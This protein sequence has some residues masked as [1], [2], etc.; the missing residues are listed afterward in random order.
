M[1]DIGGLGVPFRT[2]EEYKAM[3]E[4]AQNANRAKSAFLAHMS[5]EMRTPMNSIIG[6]SELALDA[7]IPQKTREYLNLI[8]D[9]SKWLLQLINDILDISKIESGNMKLEH[10]PFDLHEIFIACRT[11][12]APKAA[13]KNIDLFFYAEP[14]VG[15]MLIGDPMRLRQVLI[16]LLSN[17]VKF[18][19]AGI[20]K[21]AAVIVNNYNPQNEYCTLRFEIKDTGI[22]MNSEQIEQIFKPFTQADVGTTRKYGGTGLGL[23]IT[24]NII[25]LM[26]G[27]LNIESKPGA[28]TKISYEITFS[29]T[30]LEDETLKIE[31]IVNT[32]EKPLFEGDI[33]V[34]EDNNM[35][36]RVIV[37][38]LKRVGFNVELAENGREGIEI[39]RRRTEKGGSPFDLIF[40]DIHMPVMDGIEAAPKIIEMGVTTPIIAMTA[41]VMVEDVE[42]YKKIGMKDHIGK[43]FTSQLLWGL[44]LKYLSPVS[45]ME[46]QDRETEHEDEIFKNLLKSEFVKSNQNKY[47]ELIEAFNSGDIKLAHRIAHTLKSAAGQIGKTALYKAAADIEISLQKDAVLP[48]ETQMNIFK[49]ELSIA[50]EEL[51]PYLTEKNGVENSGTAGADFDADKIFR[52]FDNLEPLLKR[53]SPECLKYIGQLRQI[54]ESNEL[55]T[56]IE[57]FNFDT[58]ADIVKNIR[59][60]MEGN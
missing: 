43:P 45:F 18:T 48:A 38:H 9:N 7:E 42:L 31:N 2:A 41:N 20:V 29:T 60:K 26:G 11:L 13:E 1:N 27:K 4:I 32:I 36:Q 12:T 6:F 17:A 14:F 34:F 55:I 44:L 53:G 56:Q 3:E 46:I 54:P 33:L 50:L 8:I 19:E 16:N 30:E 24:K 40:M 5:H 59:N 39:V 57:E 28:G 52:L 49:A 58:A 10:I 35:N 37:E 15:K 23:T 25:E 51:L 47:N 22:G 21:L